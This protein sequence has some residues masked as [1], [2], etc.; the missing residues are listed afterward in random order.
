MMNFD[1]LKPA[2]FYSEF[3]PRLK[4]RGNSE[5]RGNAAKRKK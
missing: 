2:F 5:G 3:S 1:G 4:S